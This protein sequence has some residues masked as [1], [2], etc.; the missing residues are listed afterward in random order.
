MLPPTVDKILSAWS[1]CEDHYNLM[2]QHYRLQCEL[3]AYHD[4]ASSRPYWVIM[5]ELQAV[6]VSLAKYAE[7]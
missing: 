4:G 6:K 7:V 5:G 2:V 3:D 1:T